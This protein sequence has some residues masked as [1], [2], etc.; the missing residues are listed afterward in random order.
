M[1]KMYYETIDDVKKEGKYYTP[2]HIAQLLIKEILKIKES[3]RKVA[4]VCMGDGRF[5]TEYHYHDKYAKVFGIDKDYEIIQ[6]N[7]NNNPIFSDE[8]VK[9]IDCKC[10]YEKYDCIITNPPFTKNKEHIKILEHILKNNLGQDGTLGIILPEALFHAPSYKKIRQESFFNK[11]INTIIDL[12]HDSFK[13]YNNAK[14][15]IIILTNCRCTDKK[16]K[17]KLLYGGNERY[18]KQSIL[19]NE[20]ILIPRYYHHSKK[21]HYPKSVTLKSLIDENVVMT[22]KGQGSPKSEY[23]GK[24]TVPY[25]RVKD[26]V[27]NEI[28]INKLDCIPSSVADDY[29]TSKIKETDI[30]MVTRGSY[31][32]GDV[33]QVHKKDEKSIYTRELQFFR[34]KEPNDYNLTNHNLFMIMSSDDFHE[35]YESLIFIDTTLPTLNNRYEKLEI[36]LYDSET[37]ACLHEKGK[38]LF[39]LRKEYWRK[40]EQH[41]ECQIV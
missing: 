23:K 15:I 21:S 18:V 4:D 8:N 37:M 33:G 14:C 16:H 6:Y 12:P 3:S 13:P 2:L 17:V 40:Y 5:L 29:D 32:I 34:V 30:I 27:N 20:D 10:N 1:K 38:E 25:V 11:T 9:N 22:W 28:Y 24:G 26:I 35:Q 7:I 31:R 39:N 36:P 41:T 19:Y